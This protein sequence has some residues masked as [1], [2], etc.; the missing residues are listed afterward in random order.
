MKVTYPIQAVFLSGVE[1]VKAN[2]EILCSQGARNRQGP[3]SSKR[4]LDEKDM[5][6]NLPQ[7]IQWLLKSLRDRHAICDNCRDSLP[8]AE[9]EIAYLDFVLGM[10]GVQGMLGMQE[11]LTMQSEKTSIFPKIRHQQMTTATP[12]NTQNI[13]L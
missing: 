2:V 3:R 11:M 12:S 13:D 1:S 5:Q 7:T 6:N 4:G 10:A 8:Y 9:N